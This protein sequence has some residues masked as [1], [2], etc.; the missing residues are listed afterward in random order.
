M[1][2][3]G[4]YQPANGLTVIQELRSSFPLLKLPPEICRGDTWFKLC[5]Y[6]GSSKTRIALL[7]FFVKR[8]YVTYRRPAS[9]PNCFDKFTASRF[10]LA[11]HVIDIPDPLSIVQI[12]CPPERNATPPCLLSPPRRRPLPQ[13]ANGVEMPPDVS[14]E[15]LRSTYLRNKAANSRSG[16]R[17]SYSLPSY[18]DAVGENRPPPP[19]Y[20]P[21]DAASSKGLSIGIPDDPKPTFFQGSKSARA[22]QT[23]LS[24]P[25]G[26]SRAPSTASKSPG[27]FGVSPGTR[28]VSARKAAR[29]AQ[30][31]AERALAAAAMASRAA[32][33]AAQAALEVGC[34]LVLICSS[35]FASAGWCRRSCHQDHEQRKLVSAWEIRWCLVGAWVETR[36]PCVRLA[37]SFPWCWCEH[38]MVTGGE[39]ALVS[40]SMC[41]LRAFVPCFFYMARSESLL[42]DRRQC[43][44]AVFAVASRTI[45]TRLSFAKL[46]PSSTR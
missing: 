3:I 33:L 36:K 37:V 2:Q 4:I 43:T 25:L 11:H 19:S 34:V 41:C 27:R 17:K 7:R 20:S 24:G 45:N 22:R 39:K 26:S 28:A 6:Y 29:D 23:I 14:W 30:L 16:V 8:R 46:S 5:L 10:V 15:E 38:G 42:H 13:A 18:G 44:T 9:C 31:S 12:K 1:T 40:E 32:D 35:F 21:N